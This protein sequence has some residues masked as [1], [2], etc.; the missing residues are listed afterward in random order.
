MSLSNKESIQLMDLNNQEMLLLEEGHCL[1][2]QALDVCFSAGAK[3]NN[4]FRATSMETL[5]YMVSEGIG[6]TLIPELAVPK[7]RNPSASIRY[8]PFSEPKPNRRIGM[9]Y[10][11]ASYR[12]ETFQQIAAIIKDKLS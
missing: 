12:E 11:H 3:E 7:K 4:T 10:R 2:G 8:I 5:R 1:R 9:L 6:M